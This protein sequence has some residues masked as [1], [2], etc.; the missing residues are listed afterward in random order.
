MHTNKL[1]PTNQSWLTNFIGL[2]QQT[3]RTLGPLVLGLVIVYLFLRVAFTVYHFDKL[4]GISALEWGYLYLNG[5]RFDLA[6]LSPFLLLF[7]LVTL[8]PYPGL[9]RSFWWLVSGACLLFILLNGA[10]IVLLE[11]TGR[12]F[13]KSSLVL[14]GEGSW[15][16][17]LDYTVM[18]SLTG[19]F[20][21]V[22]FI[23]TKTSLH[24]LE[25]SV[26]QNNFFGR[27]VMTIIVLILV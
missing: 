11:F 19:L 26:R 12:R 2:C 22:G 13:S 5:L 3:I 23:A 7:F 14:V 27:T 10:D 20:L 15:K 6:A 4:Q 16:N 21:V 25:N 9:R 24:R 18:A 1:A 8:I 17:L